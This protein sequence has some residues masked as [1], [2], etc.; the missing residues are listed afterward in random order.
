MEGLL[1]APRGL[2]RFVVFDEPKRLALGGTDAGQ[3]GLVCLPQIIVF[4]GLGL[5]E[6]SH[7]IPDNPNFAAP[8]AY[9]GPESCQFGCPGLT[10]TKPFIL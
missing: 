10:Q 3:F 7:S 2:A 8:K 9:R 1:V 6:G 5:D 4:A